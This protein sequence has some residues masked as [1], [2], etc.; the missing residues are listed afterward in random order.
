MGT[1]VAGLLGSKV[2]SLVVIQAGCFFV[3]ECLSPVAVQ[4]PTLLK[5][6][7]NNASFYSPT[8]HIDL[9]FS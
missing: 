4:A 9:I 5:S 6:F 7:K 1:H 3:L 8:H 2:P